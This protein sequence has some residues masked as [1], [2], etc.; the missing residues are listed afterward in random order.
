MSDSVSTT[1]RG[2][3]VTV[4]STYSLF[5][6]SILRIHGSLAPE[7]RFSRRSLS[8]FLGNPSSPSFNQCLLP[9][10]N[11]PDFQGLVLLT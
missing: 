3:S 8:L 7:I 1:R 2:P 4:K 5:S 10:Y 9:E 6:L 11:V